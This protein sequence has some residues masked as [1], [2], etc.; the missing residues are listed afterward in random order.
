MDDNYLVLYFYIDNTYSVVCEKSK[1][2]RN[3]N[4]QDKTV[5]MVFKKEWFNGK[6]K[7]TGIL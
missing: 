5:E 6:I 7:Y 3:F 2:L 4:E 1:G